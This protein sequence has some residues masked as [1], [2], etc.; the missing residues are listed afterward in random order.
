MRLASGLCRSSASGPNRRRSWPRGQDPS[1]A[2]NAT[3]PRVAFRCPALVTGPPKRC[4]RWFDPPCLLETSPAGLSPFEGRFIGGCSCRVSSLHW[5]GRNFPSSRNITGAYLFAIAMPLYAFY[6]SQELVD[7]V[8]REVFCLWKN[9]CRKTPKNH[10][11]VF[12]HLAPGTIMRPP[13][14]QQ[15]A[16]DRRLAA[17]AGEPRAQVDAVLQLEEAAHS[18]GVDIIADR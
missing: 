4:G 16:P 15:N 10:I 5:A 9:L 18:I 11:G 12:L 14:S 17:E 7:F 13:P 2:R 8:K 6:I 1:H 3:L